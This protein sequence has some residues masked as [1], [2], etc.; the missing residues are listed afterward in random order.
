KNDEFVFLVIGG[1]RPE[2]NP[3]AKFL[4]S[5]RIVD[6]DQ[7]GISHFCGGS[8]ISK[9]VILTAAHCL[10]GFISP[11]TNII[12]VAGTPRRLLR[13]EHTQ[14]L[15][16]D[17]IK[18]HRSW[19]GRTL[20]ND[21]A[22]LKLKEELDINED[23]ASIIPIA[24]QKPSAGQLC[25]VIGWG[26]ILESGP[27]PDDIVSGDVTIDSDE[28]CS[29]GKLF[30]SSMM[31]CASNPKNYEVSTANGD[32]GGPLICDNKL[33]G[34]TSFAVRKGHPSHSNGFTNVYY[35]REW[36]LRNS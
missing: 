29:A 34:I 21:I 32:S 24:G 14:V 10:A 17:K 13:T 35:F 22:L 5:L 18:V 31:V 11:S 36:I 27:L 19:D 4:V 2:K 25:T 33:V 28:Y 16:V 26:L 9:K 20:S 3:L 30:Q 1:S 8:I 6:E 7:F 15:K 12:I 23:F